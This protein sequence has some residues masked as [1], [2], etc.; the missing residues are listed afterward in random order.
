DPQPAGDGDE[1]L[2]AF[3]EAR[4]PV[5]GPTL[6]DALEVEDEPSVPA[7]RVAAI[8]ASVPLGALG[9][10]GVGVTAGGRFGLGPLRGAFR[11]AEPQFIGATARAARRRRRLAELAAEAR[12][13]QAE[14]AQVTADSA[15]VAG[16]LEAL[17]AARKALPGAG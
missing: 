7:A 10:D 8:L 14:L 6:A 16:R 9:A 13:L 2:D 4:G 5:A 3:L 12:D 1:R 17:T 15:A 11:R